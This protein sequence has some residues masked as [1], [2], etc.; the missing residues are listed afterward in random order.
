MTHV[1]VHG[2]NC[3]PPRSPEPIS[4]PLIDLWTRGIDSDTRQSVLQI[5][6]RIA[7]RRLNTIKT[8]TVIITQ[9]TEVSDE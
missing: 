9:D 2:A 1:F 3:P 5:L 4:I 6:S 8:P 7:A